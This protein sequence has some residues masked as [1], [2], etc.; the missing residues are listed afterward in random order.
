MRVL[1]DN[2][3][4]VKIR[5]FRGHTQ[6]EFAELVNLSRRS[7]QRLEANKFSIKLSHKEIARLASP[8]RVPA[9][10]LWGTLP[11]TSDIYGVPLGTAELLEKQVFNTGGCLSFVVEHFPNDAAIE[12]SLIE[13]SEFFE[14]IR[15]KTT[16]F[17]QETTQSQKLKAQSKIR[18]CFRVITDQNKIDKA[19]FYIFPLM[20]VHT[21]VDED[22]EESAPDWSFYWSAKFKVYVWDPKA[23]APVIR[24]YPTSADGN[25]EEFHGVLDNKT[26]IA[27]ALDCRT[28]FSQKPDIN[29][30]DFADLKAEEFEEDAIELVKHIQEDEYYSS[31]D[32][33]ED[34]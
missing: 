18:N 16:F 31:L 7:I 19:A 13:L 15:G 14:M 2:S 26:F 20:Q 3:R 32:P 12:E 17:D 4:F 6:S 24:D 30:D 1:L 27:G 23:E 21:R 33:R 10:D 28:D 34:E 5:Q 11:L 9:H 25:A 29:D 22:N 8:L